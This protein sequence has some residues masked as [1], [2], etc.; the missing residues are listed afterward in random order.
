MATTTTQA[1]S[2]AARD[3]TDALEAV[4]GVL[5]PIVKATRELF[6]GSPPGPDDLRTVD[7]PAIE[8]LE[9][10]DDI[11]VGAGF[12]A[13]PDALAGAG[14]WLQWWSDY[15]IPRTH[16]PQQ[17]FVDVDPASESFNDYTRLPWYEVPARTHNRHVAGPYVDYLCTDQ[18]TLTF[19][20]PITGSRAFLGVV[21]ADVYAATMETA[22][23]PILAGLEEPAAL[24][25]ASA[26]VVTAAGCSRTV[27]DILRSTEVDTALRQVTQHRDGVLDLGHSWLKRC[28]DLPM[29]VV[30][31]DLVAD[32]SQPAQQGE[33]LPTGRRPS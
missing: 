8:A 25:N 16:V 14:H 5:Q 29:V 30:V 32:P 3:A 22:T 2:R 27:G 15:E 13:A 31:G 26:R 21:G 33:D 24:L 19:T 4:F 20:V 12:V 17:L 1:R 28:S 7:A 6:A 18:Y 23:Y 10:L 11:I 9:Q